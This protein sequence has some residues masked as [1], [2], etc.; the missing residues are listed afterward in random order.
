MWD[1]QGWNVDVIVIDYA[2]I[3]K[4]EDGSP[5]TGYEKHDQTWMSLAGLAG[6]RNALVVT[7]TQVNAKGQ[8]AATLNTEHSAQ[9]VGKNAHVD[10]M[11]SVNQTEVEKEIGVM[12]VG[13]DQHRHQDFNKKATCTILQQINLAQPL[14]D[15]MITKKQLVDENGKKGVDD[16]DD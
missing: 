12:R 9:W 2:D 11:F 10:A 14:L 1:R 7:A 6:E 13:I 4:P 3:L 16:G 15:S 5:T 8:S